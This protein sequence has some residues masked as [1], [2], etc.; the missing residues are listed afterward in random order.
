MQSLELAGVK[1]VQAGAEQGHTQVK[2]EVI[3][4]VGVEI[5][6][7]V[8]VRVDGRWVGTNEINTMLNSS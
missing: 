8:L 4:E 7:Q 6:V 1:V 5:G 2:L 3:V